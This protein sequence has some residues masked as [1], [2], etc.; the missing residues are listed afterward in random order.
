MT[1]VLGAFG[2]PGRSM[3]TFPPTYSMYPEYARATH[4]ELRTF[5]RDDAFGLTRRRWP[6]TCARPT[7]MSSC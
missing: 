7:L 2:G 3:L 6:R 5:S 4:T 1:H